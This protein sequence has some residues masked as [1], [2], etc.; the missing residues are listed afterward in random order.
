MY[1]S[2]GSYDEAQLLKT[3]AVQKGYSTAYIVAYKDDKRISL[4]S[5]LSELSE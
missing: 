1:C 2:T 4:D 3:N 5:A